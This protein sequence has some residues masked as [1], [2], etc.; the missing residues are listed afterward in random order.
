MIERFFHSLK[1]E[2][3]WPHLFAISRRHVGRFRTGSAGTTKNGPINRSATGVPPS[4][5]LNKWN[6]WLEI[7]EHYSRFSSPPERRG[8]HFG[9]VRGRGLRP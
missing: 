3:V 5:G 1:E 7:G 8:I 2:C 9:G 6:W 4:I